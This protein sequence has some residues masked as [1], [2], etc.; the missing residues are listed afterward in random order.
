MFQCQKVKKIHQEYLASWCG[1]VRIC[2]VIS[3]ITISLRSTW[4]ERILLIIL[5]TEGQSY[6]QIH[7]YFSNSYQL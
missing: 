4:T 2:T 6:N 3:T 7:T 1:S 5:G